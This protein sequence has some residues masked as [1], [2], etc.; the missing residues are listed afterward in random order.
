MEH[1]DRLLPR[2][3]LMQPREFSY[4]AMGTR[5]NIRIWDTVSN[6]EFTDIQE[7]ILQSTRDYE[8]Q[9]SRFRE[10]SLVWELAKSTGVSEVPRDLVT[11]LR[12]YKT[13]NT[14]SHGKFNPLIGFTL[15]DLGY[16]ANYS[17]Q[18]QSH[19][20]PAPN[21][22]TAL[23]ILDDTH[24]ELHEPVLI[25]IGAVGKGY[26][27]D[28]ITKHL[29]DRSLKRFLVDGS[30]DAFYEGN[31]EPIRIG[32]EHPDDP[33][34]AI[35]VLTLIQG[36]LCGSG[37]NRRKWNKYH[38]IVDPDTLES[39]P[40]I[41][42]TWVYTKDSTAMSDGLATCLFL[43]DPELYQKEIEFE[44]LMLNEKYQV[45]RSEGFGVELFVAE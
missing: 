15:S 5:W 30:G 23:K 4:E 29:K 13:L 21:F 17:L 16:D 2:L 31:G 34:K 24:I 40:N 9:Y 35:G 44:Y 7:W 38:H 39:P 1:R 10:T 18:P 11:M 45:K 19:I 22:S 33:T 8:E 14:L 26:F 6:S 42:A 32:L 20:R 28:I 25:D 3:R 37:G 27:V 12:I 36:S 41:L 43:T